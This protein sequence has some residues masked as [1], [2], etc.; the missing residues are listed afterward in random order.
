M[1]RKASP[2]AICAASV[3]FLFGACSDSSEPVSY[4]PLPDADG[5][6]LPDALEVALRSDPQSADDP[7]VGGALDVD[8]S[9]GPGPDGIP[10][11]L[12]QYL[13]STGSQEPITARTDSDIDGIPDYLE[14]LSGLDHLDFTSPLENGAGDTDESNSSGPA[15]DGISDAMEAYLVGRGADFPITVDSDTD[16]DGFTDFLEVRVGTDAFQDR[17]PLFH[18]V[19]DV[20]ADGLPDHFELTLDSDPLSANFPVFEGDTDD[21]GGVNGPDGDALTDGVETFLERNAVE[22][23]WRWDRSRAG[24]SPNRYPPG[25]PP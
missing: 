3:L 17:S 13:A 7:I 16:G 19:F 2:G 1:P 24:E 22:F 6:G 10:D 21:D 4:A 25:S 8:D 11:G 20:D 23:L 14:I 15:L 5:D 9:A 12:E 18:E